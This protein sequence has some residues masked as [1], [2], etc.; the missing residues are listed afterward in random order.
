MAAADHLGTSGGGTMRRS[1]IERELVGRARVGQI[2]F[3]LPR[4]F[5]LT[6]E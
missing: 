1:C 6:S 3:R 2:L 5:L 4:S